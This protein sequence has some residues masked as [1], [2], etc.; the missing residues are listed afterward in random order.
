M[1]ASGTPAATYLWRRIRDFCVASH[2]SPLLTSGYLMFAAS[3]L[4]VCSPRATSSGPAPASLIRAGPAVCSALSLAFLFVPI[5]TRQTLFW[6]IPI[7][8]VLIPGA[9]YQGG[10]RRP[11]LC[12]P[13]LLSGRMIIYRWKISGKIRCRSGRPRGLARPARRRAP[14]ALERVFP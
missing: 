7:T 5:L 1:P 4:P 3:R 12:C 9:S 6:E 14:E 2:A 8:Y 11:P 10:R 13:C